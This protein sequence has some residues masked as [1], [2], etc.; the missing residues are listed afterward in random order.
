MSLDLPSPIIYLI[1]NGKTTSKTTPSSDEF[2]S[3]LSLVQA[4]VASNISLVQ[5]R[6]KNLSARALYELTSSAVAIARNSSTRL[7]VNDR[8]DI[9]MAAHADGVHLTS[10]SMSPD[11]V[12]KS[13][14]PELLIGASTHS[15][16]EARL[17]SDM[18]ADFVLFGPV[19]ET[20]SKREY[21]APQGVRKLRE[22]S[23]AL[24]E[25]PVIAIGGVTL[26]NAGECIKAGAAG[27]A[28]ISLFSDAQGL[29]SVVDTLVG[30]SL[31][32]H[33]S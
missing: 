6:E 18:G 8:F 25:F 5:L 31:R 24:K 14:G 27:V 4:A 32:G 1:T 13:C 15:L 20:E 3:I 2:S 26:Q 7:L 28:A 16:N 22:V 29:K 11:V 9:A 21:G 17:A 33:P 12:R 10:R 30:A 19:F 23:S